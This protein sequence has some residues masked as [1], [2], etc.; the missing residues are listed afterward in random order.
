[1]TGEKIGMIKSRLFSILILPIFI[2][3]C[4]NTPTLSGTEMDIGKSTQIK[5]TGEINDPT[6]AKPDLTETTNLDDGSN[7]VLEEPEPT[8]TTKSKIFAKETN[9]PTV[10]KVSLNGRIILFYSFTGE[11]T[12]QDIDSGKV[13]IIDPSYRVTPEEGFLG[14][15]NQGCSFYARMNDFDIVEINISGMLKRKVFEFDKLFFSGHGEVVPWVSLSP[16]ESILAFKV[17]GGER[18]SYE[19][20]YHYETENIYVYSGSKQ[21]EAIK[22]SENDKGWVLEWSPDSEK[23]AYT[24]FDRDGNF[25]VYVWEKDTQMGTQITHFSHGMRAPFQLEWA[26]NQEHIAVFFRLDNPANEVFIIETNGGEVH[27]LGEVRQIWWDDNSSLVVWD[28]L[29]SLLKWYDPSTGEIIRTLKT[30]DSRGIP[31]PFGTP[32][33]IACLY[34]CF[35]HNGHGLVTFD[36]RT[37]IME[38]FLNLPRIYDYYAWIP[39]SLD[40]PGENECEP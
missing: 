16:S 40:F 33:K 5:G 17:S 30:P 24:D 27:T 6:S 3:G 4:Q 23:L 1:M 22:V 39:I 19:G 7:P 35:G 31:Q 25:Q 2:I 21:E 32:E 36:I 12:L 11:I 28:D 38:Q 29:E 14:W 20:E 8:I 18:I 9:L 26:P 34:D 13:R 37:Q 10:D 15:T